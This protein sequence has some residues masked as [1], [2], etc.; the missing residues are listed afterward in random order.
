MLYIAKGGSWLA[1]GQLVSTLSAFILS[2]AYA[3]LLSPDVYGTYK[4][5]LSIN[6]LLIITTLSGMDSAITQSVSRGFDGTMKLGLLEKF[7]WGLYGSVGALIISSYYLYNDNFFL[8]FSFLIISVFIPFTEST[9]TYNSMLW[10]KK[11][12][13]VQAKYNVINILVTLMSVSFVLYL[14][15]NIYLILLTYLLSLTIPNLFFLWNTNKYHKSNDAVD[16][17]AVRYGKTLSFIGVLALLFSQLDKILVFHYI[18]PVNLAIYSLAVAP[19]DQIKGLMK[20]LNSLAMPQLS[21]RT[22]DEIKKNI[23]SKIGVLLLTITSIVIVYILLAPLF[24]KMFFPKY[25]SSVIYT[26]ILSLSLIPVVIAGFIY[27]ILESQKS[28]KKIY[29]Y[30]IYGNIFGIIILFPLVYYGGIWGAI[31]SRILTRCFFLIHSI[32]LLK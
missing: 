15:N 11:L 29:Q 32:Y 7:K 22:I 14:T 24:F 27:T 1:A 2:V 8:G 3:N 5:I 25:L 16:E 6:S 28:E 18:G 12:F 26:Q 20:N 10:G 9:D 21:N 30:N 31:F 19:T 4:F 17:D 23:P 13:N